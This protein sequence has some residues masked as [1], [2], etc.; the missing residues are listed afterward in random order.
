MAL[1]WRVSADGLT[2]EQMWDKIASIGA[3]WWENLEKL[4]W[5]DELVERMK[6]LGEVAFLSSPG[7]L[8]KWPKSVPDAA[9]GKML[10]VLKY[11]PDTPL[12]LCHKKELCA[13]P[14]TI[15]IDDSEKK[16]KSFISSGGK[17]FLWPNQYKIMD[18]E[19]ELDEIFEKIEDAVEKIK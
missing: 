17:S 8:P 7:N 3:S 11:F 13:S 2:E 1:A 4:P 19:T 15:L 18:G 14:N 5:A 16:V 10:W 6:R 12:I 9:K